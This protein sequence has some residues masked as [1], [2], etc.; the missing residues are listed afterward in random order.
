VPLLDPQK[1]EAA[2]LRNVGIL[3]THSAGL[4]GEAGADLGLEHDVGNALAQ[5]RGLVPHN[6]H[7]F[8]RAL[9]LLG[10]SC[11]GKGLDHLLVLQGGSAAEER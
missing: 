2:R 11:S 4:C 8:H 6:A 5:P 10:G 7:G 1:L 3:R 9:Q